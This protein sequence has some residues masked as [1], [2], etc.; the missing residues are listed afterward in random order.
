MHGPQCTLHT[1]VDSTTAP[2]TDARGASPTSTPPGSDTE[3]RQ[4]RL[5]GPRR[6]NE[7]VILRQCSAEISGGAS[8]RSTSTGISDRLACA[9]MVHRGGDGAVEVHGT[10]GRSGRY[11]LIGRA[12]WLAPVPDRALHRARRGVYTTIG[13]ARAPRWRPRHIILLSH[14]RA[15]SSLLTQLI[16]STDEVLGYGELHLRYERPQHLRAMNGK[17]AVVT[18]TSR[19]TSPFVIDKILHDHL[20]TPDALARVVERIETVL[21]VRE[22]TATMQSLVASFGMSQDEALEYYV[23]RLR[24]LAALASVT[25]AGSAVAL[26][27]DDLIDRTTAAFA[28]IETQLGLTT[29]LD[30]RYEPRQRG[31]DPSANLASGR[32]LRDDKIVRHEASVD[33]AILER[34]QSAFDDSMAFLA[35]HCVTLTTPVE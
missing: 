7:L 24:S 31:S 6:D 23:T 5:S 34:A 11:A 19:P 1:V 12:R 35:T 26:T 33:A 32:I 20:L 2:G 18:R 28:L 30:E 3:E 15:G 10:D 8:A 4:H 14:M 25:A 13:I 29:P 21:L 16:A 9:A 27:Y 17:V 22:P